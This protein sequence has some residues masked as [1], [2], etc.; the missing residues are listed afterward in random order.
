MS[1]IELEILDYLSREKGR[2]IDIAK[3]TGLN[4]KTVWQA[5]QRLSERGLV[6]KDKFNVYSI[7]PNGLS[8][9][10]KA[11]QDSSIMRRVLI[12][13]LER[14]IDELDDEDLTTI[15]EIVNKLWGGGNAD[16]N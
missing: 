9:L 4:E 15:R 8:Q 13:R 1:P 10:K 14:K 3:S 5:L 7:T 12:K 16:I 6:K 11:K 2:A